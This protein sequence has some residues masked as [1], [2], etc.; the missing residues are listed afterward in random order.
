[1]TL[2]LHA[3]LKQVD[4]EAED[5]GFASLQ[6]DIRKLI[7]GIE[8][9]GNLPPEQDPKYDKQLQ[10]QLHEFAAE[11]DMLETRY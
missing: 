5:H 2:L 11:R 10:K 4:S 1:M 3:V 6:A 9:E 7:Q 8:K